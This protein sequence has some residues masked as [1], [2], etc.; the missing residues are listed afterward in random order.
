[1]GCIFTLLRTTS[2]LSWSA[3]FSDDAMFQRGPIG[4]AVYGFSD[5]GDVVEVNVSG[6]SGTGATVSYSVQ[7]LIEPWTDTS[8]CSSTHC[9]DAKTPL[10]PA[11]GNFTFSAVL[12]PE[13]AGGEFS[14][15]ASTS[16]GL[17]ST[18]QLKGVTYG[19]IYYCR[20]YVFHFKGL[21]WDFCFCH[22][23]CISPP[24]SQRTIQHGSGDILHFLCR[25]SQA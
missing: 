24:P 18:I 9:I 21:C 13:T 1:V 20:F 19:D 10:P 12:R 7:A 6:I 17:N 23:S 3:G 16:S 5:S 8:G 25:H 22:C 4:V 14:I 2:A 15:S 11:H